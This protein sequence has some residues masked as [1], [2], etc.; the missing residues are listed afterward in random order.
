M[1]HAPKICIVWLPCP[2]EKRGGGRRRS[3]SRR[4]SHGRPGAR[5][6][7]LG[8][9]K[10]HM[11]TAERSPRWDGSGE[12]RQETIRTHWTRGFGDAAAAGRLRRGRRGGAKE[13]SGTE[14]TSRFRNSDVESLSGRTRRLPFFSFFFK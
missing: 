3:R 4:E 8:G 5:G 2:W 10:G 6:S 11:P 7:D 14:S 12:T 13:D 1:E 9:G